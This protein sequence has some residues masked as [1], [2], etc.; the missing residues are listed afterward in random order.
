MQ[1]RRIFL[2]VILIVSTSFVRVKGVTEITGGVLI[3]KILYSSNAAPD[4]GI[5]YMDLDGSGKTE[6]IHLARWEE[7]TGFSISPCGSKI[8]YGTY[9]PDGSKAGVYLVNVDGSD[10]TELVTG[11]IPRYGPVFTLDGRE[12]FFTT[13]VPAEGKAFSVTLEGTA[14]TEITDKVPGM[15]YYSFSPDGKYAVF[16]YGFGEIARIGKWDIE[17]NRVTYI[18]EENVL[19][20]VPRV[21]PNGELI[22]YGVWENDKLHLCVMD[23]EGTNRRRLTY[24]KYVGPQYRFSPDSKNIVFPAERED[25]LEAIY[26]IGV[27]GSNETR[28]TFNQ[29]RDVDPVYSPDGRFIAFLSF[30]PNTREIFIMNSDGTELKRLTPEGVNWNIVFSPMLVGNTIIDSYGNTHPVEQ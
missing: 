23:T 9:F 13:A 29:S 22:A 7:L 11:V 27:D 20:Y 26:K 30:A 24:D 8:A 19:A 1:G 28:L 10:K 12:L 2:Y 3:D 18:S 4:R 17:S 5:Y 14:L 6:I 16:D 25:G 15:G 21:S